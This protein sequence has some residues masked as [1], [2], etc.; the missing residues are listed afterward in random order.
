MATELFFLFDT[1][2]PWSYA[3]TSLVNEINKALPEVKLNL[4][5]CA[6]FSHNDET[7]IKAANI[8]EVTQL[9]SVEF[10]ELYIEQLSQQKDSTLTANLMTWAQM[11]T[12]RLA[13]PLLNALQHAHFHQGNELNN[14]ASLADIIE[15]LKLSPPAKVLKS[16]ALSKDAEALIHEIYALQDIINTQAIPALLLAINDELILLNH[17]F[18][19]KEPS[20]II[21]AVKLEI[22]KYA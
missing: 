14:K 12:P 21:D 5:H 1:H 17:N 2:C 10:S 20:A 3:T 9:S 22:Q 13:L 7:N 4:W 19:L 15:E 6:H 8:K 16:D 18:Y 11:K